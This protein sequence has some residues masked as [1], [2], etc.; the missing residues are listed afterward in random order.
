MSKF[1][2]LSAD[3]FEDLELFYPYYRLNEEHNAVIASKKDKIKGKHGYE[4]EVDIKFDEINPKNYDGL[5]IPGGKGPETVRRSKEAVNVAKKFMEEEKPV[6]SICH[7]IQVLISAEVLEDKEATCWYGVADDLEAAGGD[8]KDK[9][10]VVD[11]N[12]VS[13]RHP[14][15]L[16]KFMKEFLSFF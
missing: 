10:V 8:F 5:L 3:G 9:S 14:G 6:A 15:D 7:G 4:A 11:N 16:D 1:L 13:S 2:I 12:L